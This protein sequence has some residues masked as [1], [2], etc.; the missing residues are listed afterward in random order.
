MMDECHET[1]TVYIDN[2][3]N[4]PR[5][6][7]QHQKKNRVITDTKSWV[8]WVEDTEENDEVRFESILREDNAKTKYLQQQIISKMQSYRA[9]DIKKGKFD[10]LCFVTLTDIIEKLKGSSLSCFYCKKKVQLWYQQSRDPGQWTLERIDNS[11]GHNRDNV[12]I[13]CLSCNIKRRCIFHERF[14]FTKQIQFVKQKE[15]EILKTNSE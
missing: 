3:K 4:K 1:K 12:E 14:R 7:K 6:Q 11:L 15:E 2:Q 5:H 9:Q 10:E 8:K 13:A